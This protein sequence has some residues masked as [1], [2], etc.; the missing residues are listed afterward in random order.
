MSVTEPELQRRAACPSDMRPRKT[1]RAWDEPGHAHFL[2][3]SC[4]KRAALLVQ[5]RVRR[6]VVEAMEQ[7]RATL[8]ISLLAYV[9][10]PDHVHVLLLPKSGCPM[11]QVLAALKSSV[12]RHAREHLMD[13]GQREWLDRLTV[14]YPSRTI[15]RFWQPG[16]GYDRNV[17]RERTV[18]EVMDY[19]HANPVRRGLVESPAEWAW[20]SARVWAG[21]EDVPIAMDLFDL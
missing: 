20:S 9:I 1:R 10:I 15:L 21:E 2:T 5:D 13:T 3:Y 17:W 7:T 19:M 4:H 12:S 11:R 8:N 18:R 16:G 14:R 6:W